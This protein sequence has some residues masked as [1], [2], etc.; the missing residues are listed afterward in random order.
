[1]VLL[2]SL[3]EPRAGFETNQ[4]FNDLGDRWRE[5]PRTAQ[6]KGFNPQW[7]LADVIKR[8]VR[9]RLVYSAA[10]VPQA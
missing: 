5:C 1:M 2:V 3:H 4:E 10:P 8:R 6:S 9:R 7:I